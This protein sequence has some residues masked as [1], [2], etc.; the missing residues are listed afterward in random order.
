MVSRAA[1]N[2]R[3]SK[4]KTLL[5][6]IIVGIL[7]PT[8]TGLAGVRA[9]IERQARDGRRRNSGRWLAGQDAAEFS[10]SLICI[11][12]AAHVLM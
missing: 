8:F 5:G 7:F 4:V 10:I 12:I 11:A 9:A 2:S 1:E 3:L 6:L